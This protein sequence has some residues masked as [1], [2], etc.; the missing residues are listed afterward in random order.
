[1]FNINYVINVGYQIEALNP[2]EELNSNG[3]LSVAINLK[4]QKGVDVLKRLSSKADVLLEPYR[5]GDLVLN[6]LL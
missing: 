6:P 2:Q 4:S 1:M 3:K 5:A